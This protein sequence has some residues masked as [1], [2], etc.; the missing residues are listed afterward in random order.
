MEHWL[1]DALLDKLKVDPSR[2]SNVL[3]IGFFGRDPQMAANIANSFADAYVQTSLELRI[4]PARRQSAWFD[5]QIQNL[6]K[7]LEV[8]Q[9]S[10]SAYQ[11]KNGIVAVDD[12]L[13][14]ESSRLAEISSQLVEAQ[15]ATYDYSSRL[16]QVN[17]ATSEKRMQELPDISNNPLLQNMKADLARSEAK[18]AELSERFDRNHPSR[19]SAMAEV[20]SLRARI[21]QESETAKG[22]I[23]GAEQFAGRTKE[24]SAS[25]KAAAR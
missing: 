7:A 22:S 4:D 24:Q 23:R 14:V 20:D 13:D 19:I 17:N 5:E 12:R 18:L 10:L 9:Q 11:Q 8:S 6:R 21:A 3:T 15:A 25:V 16:Q 1:A 2:D